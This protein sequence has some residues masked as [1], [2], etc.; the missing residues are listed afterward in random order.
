[1]MEE[2]AV[3]VIES[4]DQI[5]I[6][7]SLSER[8]DFLAQVQA[9]LTAPGPKHIL[10]LIM[11]SEF[12]SHLAQQ[13][14]LQQLLRQGEVLVKFLPVELR[15]AIEKPAKAVGLDFE[16]GLVDQLLLDVQGEPAALTLLQFNLLSLWAKRQGNLI[17]WD[18]Y[19]EVGGGRLAL[20]RA[21]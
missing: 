15:Q 16:E 21:A 5:F 11:R 17:T 8:K 3:I 9:V 20:E 4:F 2:P 13:K 12:V 10:I 7:S 19:Y 14:E 6:R 1:G 18:H